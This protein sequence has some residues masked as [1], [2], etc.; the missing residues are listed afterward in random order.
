M[1]QLWYNLSTGT[2]R[3]CVFRTQANKSERK[4][5]FGYECIS[6]NDLLVHCSST[7]GITLMSLE[8]FV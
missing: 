7:S 8:F 6:L 4:M 5:S 3:S 2:T 1:S